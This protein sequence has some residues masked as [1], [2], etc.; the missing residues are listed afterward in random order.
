LAQGVGLSSGGGFW[1]CIKVCKKMSLVTAILR[2]GVLVILAWA[3]QDED[4]SL[5]GATCAAGDKSCAPVQRR[6][7]LS[8]NPETISVVLPCAGEGDFAR[9]TVISV[10]DSVPG[11]SGGPILV[12][13]VIVDDGSKPPMLKE[14]G[15]EF[16]E[17]YHVKIERHKKTKGLIRAKLAGGTAATGDVIVFF[18]CHVA[19]QPGWYTH[20]FQTMKSNY[21]RIVVPQIT[22]LDIDTWT[23]RSHKAGVTKCY[24]T[25]DGDFKWFD[26]ESN[27]IPVLSGGLLGISHR[28]WNETGGYDKGMR[29]WGGENVDQS[30]RTWLCGGE[31]TALPESRVAH[32]WRREEDKRTER[33]YSLQVQ[34]VLRNRARAVGGWYDQFWLKARDYPDVWYYGFQQQSPEDM[35][36]QSFTKAK[37]RLQCRPFAWYLWR[38]R[39]IFEEGGLIPHKTFMLE[40]GK[41]GMCLTFM[42]PVGTHPMGSD[43]ASIQPCGSPQP[44]QRWPLPNPNSQRWHL[45]NQDVSTGRCCSGLRVWN[46][47]QCLVALQ[48]QHKLSTAVCQVTQAQGPQVWRFETQSDGVKGHLR[49]FDGRCLRLKKKGQEYRLSLENC[50]KGKG[51]WQQRAVEEPIERRL[52]NEAQKKNPTLF[53]EDAEF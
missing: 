20:F 53:Q 38:F 4:G 17:K 44:N 18:D 3:A 42:G 6:A 46:T 9:K 10:S 43:T 39:N 27:D 24:L 37:E 19:P 5:D 30:L 29:G 21:R 11:G 41:S 28:W 49:H 25:W 50:Q 33:K 26:A 14:L 16:V 35:N 48:D 22:D 52:Y 51:L 32:M 31:I 36:L 40:A 1:T 7:D 23:E 47:D 13:I 45:A 34:D 12:D 2:F 8:W 15:Q